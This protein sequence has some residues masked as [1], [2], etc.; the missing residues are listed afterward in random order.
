MQLN[1]Y[2]CCAIILYFTVY[3]YMYI[4]IYQSFNTFV[5]IKLNINSQHDA[6]YMYVAFTY[7][8]VYI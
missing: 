5:D 2:N 8:H 3:V 7:I 6:L 1:K 4:T